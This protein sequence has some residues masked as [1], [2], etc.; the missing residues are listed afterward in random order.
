MSINFEI[1]SYVMY[2]NFEEGYYK[3]M[4]DVFAYISKYRN[5]NHICNKLTFE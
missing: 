5:N 2:D 1:E 3:N 4:D